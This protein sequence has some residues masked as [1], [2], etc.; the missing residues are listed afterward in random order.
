MGA[1]VLINS[2]LGFGA[3]A[4]APAAIVSRLN[5]EMRNV[6]ALSKVR[7]VLAEQGFDAEPGPPEAMSQRIADDVINLRKIAETAGV[8]PR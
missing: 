3:P 4:G 7:A 1:R 6:L 2:K 8:A 5:A